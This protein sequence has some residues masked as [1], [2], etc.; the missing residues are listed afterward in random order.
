MSAQAFPRLA[1]VAACSA[2]VVGLVVVWRQLGWLA[3][4]VAFV[5]GGLLAL[6]VTIEPTTTADPESVLDVDGRH[7]TAADVRS[8]LHRRRRDPITFEDLN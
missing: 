8:L 3:A 2:Y 7:V 6:V 1:L 5:G 4:V